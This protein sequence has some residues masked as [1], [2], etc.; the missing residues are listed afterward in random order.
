M[1]TAI[2]GVPVAPGVR[3]ARTPGRPGRGPTL[4]APIIKAA[5]VIDGWVKR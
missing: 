1:T 2:P 4:D 5:N 3:P